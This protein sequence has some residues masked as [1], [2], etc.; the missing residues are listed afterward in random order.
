LFRPA[1]GPPVHAPR[2]LFVTGPARYKPGSPC[3][4]FAGWPVS[5]PGGGHNRTTGNGLV[6]GRVI[7]AVP[8]G[9]SSIQDW[10]PQVSVFDR[11]LFQ[12]LFPKIL[13]F[14]SQG[15]SHLMR[16]RD[17]DLVDQILPRGAEELQVSL[18]N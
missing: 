15:V 17:T 5:A 3:T 8:G 9:I 1:G 7:T 12:P 18:I 4:S 14:Y 10:G 16:E 2:L 13:F 11:L 6:Q